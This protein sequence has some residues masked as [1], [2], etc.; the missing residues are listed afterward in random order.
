MNHEYNNHVLIV[1][2]TY[3]EID[4][5]QLMV[6]MLLKLVPNSDVLVVD[7]NSPDGTGYWAVKKSLGNSRV[8][9]IIRKNERGLGSAVICALFYALENDYQ[10]VINMDADFSHSIEY[11]TEI[12]MKLEQENTVDVVIGSRY[13]RGGGTLGWSL[14]RR[15]VSV[16]INLFTRFVLGLKTHDNSGAFRGYR[17]STLRNLDF[18]KFISKGYSF[19]EEVLYCL[20]VSGAS[21]TELPIIFVDRKRGISKINGKEAIKSIAIIFFLGLLRPFKKKVF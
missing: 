14:K 4:N 7:D 12:L 15:V 21:F 9:T 3:D 19:F 5:I 17:V 18:D 20:K 11:V 1:V 6:N 2:A 8:K 10:F 16:C 13:V